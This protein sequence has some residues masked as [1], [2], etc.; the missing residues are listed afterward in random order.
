MAEEIDITKKDI[1]VRVRDPE[2]EHFDRLIYN[3]HKGQEE[4]WNSDKR[5]IAVLAGTQGGKALSCE[6]H[7]PTRK[8]F[9]E[10]GN[11][12][13]GDKVFG[14]D[15]EL[16]EVLF[17]HEP[18]FSEDCYEI[19]FDDKTSVVCDGNHLWVTSNYAERHRER[20]H[21]RDRG[22][23]CHY[24]TARTTS[25]LFRG[26]SEGE[27]YTIRNC[28]QINPGQTYGD[29]LR[30][31]NKREKKSKTEDVLRISD[32]ICER[33]KRIELLRYLMDQRG[34]TA[35][36]GQCIWPARSDNEAEA[37]RSLVAS[38]GL[39]C[40]KNIF[41]RMLVCTFNCYFRVFSYGSAGK[42]HLERNKAKPLIGRSSYRYIRK[43]EKVSP[44][45]VRCI[46]VDSKDKTYLCG[47]Q[48]VPTHNTSFG[49]LWL[50]REI[51][52]LG[53]FQGR[54]GGDYLA[55]TANFGLFKLKMLPAILDLFVDTYGLGR[56]WS[57]DRIIELR[58]SPSSKFLA[59]S[60]N[61][62][63][64]G[65]IIL[66]SAESSGGLESATAKGAWLDEAGQDSF[67]D[68]TWRAANSRVAIESGRIL[69]TTTLYNF[70][71][72]KTEVYDKWANGHSDFHVVHF[73]S[74]DNPR[75][76]VEE[77]IRAR[78]SMPEWRFDM[79]YR[80]R[81]S[82]PAGMIYDCFLDKLRPEG[83]LCMPFDIPVGWPRYIGID[84]GGVNTACVYIAMDPATGRMFCYREY[85]GGDLTAGEHA[86]EILRGE[87][88]Y[89][90][91]IGGAPS[92]G[93]WRKEFA[94]SGLF[95]KRPNVS[96]V[97][98]GITRTYSAIKTKKLIFFDNL[99][100]KIG[101]Q[102]AH[103]GLL[104]EVRSYS[105]VVDSNGNPTSDIED[106]RKY[107]KLDALRYVVSQLVKSVGENNASVGRNPL[108]LTG[109]RISR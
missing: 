104:G 78:D 40:R 44:R 39:K 75:F 67:T 36:T 43:I 2:N 98:I 81:Y 15:G 18:Y 85:F 102:E 35:N 58:P 94:S 83:N 30:K 23:D 12:R 45:M 46:T 103:R 91:C 11:I 88:K 53:E 77:Y 87:P 105:R 89:I 71:Y 93:Q 10:I 59:N 90:E 108:A 99:N 92:E 61:D 82:K 109:R 3:F 25:E 54:G 37:F 69:M 17:A 84:F 19:T 21:R 1:L 24:R 64:W 28:I 65:R 76:S 51:Y 60:A 55:V 68:E 86:K 79:R 97:E 6:T 4:A 22:L 57:G 96:E 26:I 20:R 38:F 16:C 42:K 74:C 14:S 48:M 107:H 13:S 70:G 5:F 62:K 95:V 31:L 41:G 73:D 29:I 100:G 8:G 66:R 33:G 63:M 9:V 27:L 49:P 80:G 34:W 47:H 52:G 32:V 72:L 50:H 106:K 56:Y 7:I 101:S